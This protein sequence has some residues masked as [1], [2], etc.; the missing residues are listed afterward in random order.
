M[1]GGTPNFT[2]GP[3]SISFFCPSLFP[4]LFAPELVATRARCVA[5]VLSR[6]PAQLQTVT[7]HARPGHRWCPGVSH[8]F[9]STQTL[10]RVN[11]EMCPTRR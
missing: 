9:P 4:P 3:V 10:R 7:F 8:A 11:R 1:G 2:N 6:R 5:S